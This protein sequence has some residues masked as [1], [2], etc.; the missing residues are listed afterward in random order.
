M[1]YVGNDRQYK[2][3][4]QMHYPNKQYFKK[5]AIV[6]DVQTNKSVLEGIAMTAHNNRAHPKIA[7][8]PVKYQTELFRFDH[9]F[10]QAFVSQHSDK[11]KAVRDR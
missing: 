4:K 2:E 7:E 6:T 5:I 11:L 9:E 3:G 10:E 8:L 1:K